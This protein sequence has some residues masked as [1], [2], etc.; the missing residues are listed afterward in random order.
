MFQSMPIIKKIII[1]FVTLITISLL[2]LSFLTYTTS[3]DTLHNRTIKEMEGLLDVKKE[4]ISDYHKSLVTDIKIISNYYNV[5]YNL[6]VLEKYKEDTTSKE[7]VSSTLMLET[8]L[9]SW[10]TDRAD[11]DDIEILN[12]QRMKLFS[13]SDKNE[14]NEKLKN[15]F[16]E[17]IQIISTVND[18]DTSSI[19]N[20]EEITG[21]DMITK[22]YSLDGIH[23]GYVVVKVNLDRILPSISTYSGLGESGESIL[24]TI[25]GDEIVFVNKPRHNNFQPLDK[26][27]NVHDESKV[28]M[29][30]AIN[31]MD[32][33]GQSVDYRGVSV[34]S[35]WGYIEGF[36]WGIVTEIDTIEAMYDA[37]LLVQ[38]LIVF[39]IIVIISSII[40]SVVIS[41]SL[42]QPINSLRDKMIR[43]G[44]S[45]S[46]SSS[47]S[48]TKH[49]E[50]E[51]LDEEFEIMKKTIQTNEETMKTKISEAIMELKSILDILNKTVLVSQTD[52]NGDITYVNEIFCKTT[53]YDK[54]ELIGQNHRLL[55]SNEHPDSFYK[56]LWDNITTG[57]SWE[58]NIKN[59]KKDGTHYWVHTVIS[60]NKF[61]N[62]NG[63]TS[64]RLDITKEKKY[65]ELIKNNENDL[66]EQIKIATEE[67]RK[68]DIQKSEFSAMV[69]HELKTPLTPIVL[70]C[71]ML[72][73]KKQGDLNLEQ[74]DSIKEILQ[75]TTTLQSLIGDLLD[76]QKLDMNKITFEHK[77][78][79]PTKTIDKII[80][81]MS[82][83]VTDKQIQFVNSSSY[84]STLI[85]DENRIAQVFRNMVKNS[86]AFVPQN[87]GMIEI[88]AKEKENKILFYVKDNGIGISKENQMNLFQKFYQV[89]TSLTRKHKGTGLG[90]AICK[91]IVEGLRGSIWV[92]SDEGKGTTFYFEIPKNPPNNKDMVEFTT[93]SKK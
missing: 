54:E 53:G 42:T 4:K 82:I 13:L 64:I 10:L 26:Y 23:I 77:Q 16:S 32:G 24:G 58:G 36:E 59:Q 5:K 21:L 20:H 63:Y 80:K 8:Q 7:F 88:G 43:F 68:I 3:M 51:I 12:I 89:D 50:I 15:K 41:R 6:P 83:N 90:L 33:S 38:E 70:Y 39:N 93:S 2:I 48:H 28:S 57:K 79:I 37:D 45:S 86:M 60:P 55:K 9:K 29:Y 52:L 78:F 76:A 61:I 30:S 81:K 1:S 22:V 71:N 11:I 62:N 47:S 31:R 66:K 75:S 56:D 27:C 84:K 73:N 67:L 14:K 19:H 46:S 74:I 85:S 72:L 18:V 17:D 69:S 35:A 49:S 34:I 87:G 91:G 44:A 40:V 65:E 25:I 92:D